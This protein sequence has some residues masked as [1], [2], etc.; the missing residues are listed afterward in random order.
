M[1]QLAVDPLD[2]VV[3][4][5][6]VAGPAPQEGDHLGELLG[7]QHPDR[8]RQLG[9]ARRPTSRKAACRPAPAPR[10]NPP[11]RASPGGRRSPAGPSIPAGSSASSPGPLSRVPHPVP[12]LRDQPAVL[13]DERRPLLIGRAPPQPPDGIQDPLM[14]FLQGRRSR[15]GSSPPRV[16][17]RRALRPWACL[18]RLTRSAGITPILPDTGPGRNPPAPASL[19]GSKRRSG[20]DRGKSCTDPAASALNVQ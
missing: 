6:P 19:P 10:S 15:S 9:S 1:S 7:R 20:R 16:R 2:V 13:G 4:P 8:R 17:V 5:H 3:R 14:E 12:P 18:A 11:R